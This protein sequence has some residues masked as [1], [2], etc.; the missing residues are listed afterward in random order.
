MAKSTRSSKSIISTI[1]HNHHRIR[2]SALS[3]F[4]SKR[5]VMEYSGSIQLCVEK[6]CTRLEEFCASQR[7]VN[8]YVALSA[9]TIDVI[10][11][12]CYGKAYDSLGKPDF[13]AELEKNM[14]SAGELA[15]LLR[16]CPWIFTLAN[17]L[18]YSIAIRLDP[19]V[20]GMINRRKVGRS[21][22]IGLLARSRIGAPQPFY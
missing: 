15:L 2:R 13:D 18:P 1:P 8:L 9:L 14:S 7:P 3:P 10:S 12:Y 11:L 20:K 16:Q 21:S 5:S 6:L 19:K 4:F 22:F 17:L